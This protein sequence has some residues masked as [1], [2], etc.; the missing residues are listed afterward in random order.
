MYRF[1][2]VASVMTIVGL[3][4]VITLSYTPSQA[5]C[6]IAIES[7]CTTL[8]P[9]LMRWT[10]E[11]RIGRALF[12]GLSETDP[13]TMRPGPGVA[14]RWEVSPDGLVYTFHL[15]DDARWS[16][17]DPV[18]AEDFYW[19]WERA[20]NARLGSEYSNLAFPIK[21]AKAYYDSILAHAT[22]PT[23]PVLPLAEVGVRTEGSHKLIVELEN[24]C[25]Y[26]LEILAN[27]IL[28]PVHRA[29]YER[30]GAYRWPAAAA[31]GPSGPYA[32]GHD[33]FT[34]RHIAS[35][36][37]TMVSNGAYVLEEWDFKRRMV[38]QKNPHY[39]DRDNVPLERIEV[40]PIEDPNT[41]F[42]A[43]ETRVVEWMDKPTS[44]IMQRL[45]EMHRQGERE[46]FHR[47]PNYGTYFYVFNCTKPPFDDAH[48]RRAFTMAVDK[49]RICETVTG[50][51]ET[52][53]AVLVPPLGREASAQVGPDGTQYYY[54]QPAGLP[55]DVERA[56]RELEAAGWAETDGRWQRDGTP[57]PAIE[58]SYN[59]LEAHSLIAQAIGKMW[60]EAFGVETTLRNVE[61]KVYDELR[62]NKE[63]MVGRYSWYGDYLDPT[64]F[65]NMYRTGDGFNDAGWSD[66]RYDAL[67]EQAAREANPGKRFDLLR[68]AETLLVE[69]GLPVLPIYHYVGVSMYRSN[70]QGVTDNIRDW[71]FIKKLSIKRG[72]PT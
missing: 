35:Q 65:L 9:H 20:L 66:P 39:W 15:R 8:D 57:F 51:G 22:D 36:A 55:Y 64:T 13:E 23:H 30:T 38:L 56:R 58:I 62:K 25:T 11:H 10:H 18:T 21:N 53:A 43:Y 19:G 6:V 40:L 42:M 54:D 45:V 3:I 27:S 7:E 26:F 14:H 33:N 50:I 47:T 67:L 28:F 44:R 12:E 70:V 24:P 2:V 48:V 32:P 34:R 4:A 59:T 72:E 68:Q 1:L 61:L 16:N 71:L 63:Y 52:P 29:T 41:S 49:L 31:S 37:G 60:E 17:G 69:Q 5:D 46:D